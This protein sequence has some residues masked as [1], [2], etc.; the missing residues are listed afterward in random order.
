MVDC[1]GQQVAADLNPVPLVD[2]EVQG[3]AGLPG[4]ARV[5]LAGLDIAVYV[6]AAW[7]RAGAGLGADLCAPGYAQMPQVKQLAWRGEEAGPGVQADNPLRDLEARQ[8]LVEELAGGSTRHAGAP[9]RWVLGSGGE[10]HAGGGSPLQPGEVGGARAQQPAAGVVRGGAVGGHV[11][12][13]W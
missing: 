11:Q 2:I 9:G 13:P 3:S 12:K 1:S 4:D 8:L 7:V 6:D 5:E 10:R